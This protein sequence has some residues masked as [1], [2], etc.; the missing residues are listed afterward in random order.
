MGLIELDEFDL[1]IDKYINRVIVKTQSSTKVYSYNDVNMTR[2]DIDAKELNG[3][4]VTVEYAIKITNVGQ[5]AGYARKIVDY[6]P[7]GFNFNSTENKDWYSEGNSLYSVILANDKIEA[8][9]SKI[10]NLTLTKEM[11]EDTTGTYTNKVGIEESYNEL[12]L[13]DRNS[14]AGND[15][16][17]AQLIISIRT[18]SAALYTILILSIILI[19]GVGTYFIKIKVLDVNKEERR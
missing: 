16:A 17:S 19:V 11:T 7:E 18:G 8:G 5:V 14:K 15:N 6:I 10:I 13:A 9:D 3:A 2:V 4:E 12:N 1:K